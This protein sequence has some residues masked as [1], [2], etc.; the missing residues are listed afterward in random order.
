VPPVD[1]RNRALQ[2][3]DDWLYAY[4][5]P[6]DLVLARRLVA[7][8]MARRFDK[9]PP[10]FRI[11]QDANGNLLYTDQVDAVL[12][13]TTRPVCAAG[14]GDALF[15]EALAWR[16]AHAMA[17][18]LS[19]DAKQRDACWAMYLQTLKRAS[20]PNANEQQ[21]QPNDG[22]APWIQER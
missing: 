10:P 14:A 19:K 21:V 20:I 1:T 2:A 8:G 7:P 16:V 15:R 11:G 17:M 12:E 9:N 3:S 18:G 6:S 5:I 22:D 4:R 13:Y